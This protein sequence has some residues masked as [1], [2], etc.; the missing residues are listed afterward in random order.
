[1]IADRA[2]RALRVVLRTAVPDHA[3]LVEKMEAFEREFGPDLDGHFAHLLA[4]ARRLT[5]LR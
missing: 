4:G 5:R 3:A 1:M 2:S